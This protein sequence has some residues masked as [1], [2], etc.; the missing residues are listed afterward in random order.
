MPSIL[1]VTVHR[2]RR[3]AML[4]LGVIDEVR[5]DTSATI[6]ALVV[7]IISMALLGLGGWFWWIT[8]GL[9]D[10]G[11]VFVKTVLLGTAFSAGLWLVWLLV[12]YAVLRR[13]SGVTVQIEQ[14]LRGA[15]F[16][17]LPLAVGI[18]MVVPSV[19]FGIGLLALGG[20]VVATQVAVERTI[21]RSGGDVL[22]ANLAGFGAWVIVMSL[23]ATGS[24]QIGPGPFLAESIWDAV[25]GASVIFR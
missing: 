6:P 7:A 12:I 2:V 20:W 18:L 24:N 9:L 13:I 5:F 11:T 3:L 10:Q 15:G 23:L 21:G 1:S 25:T 4:D 8:S 16:A 17:C 19:S 14:L 22:I